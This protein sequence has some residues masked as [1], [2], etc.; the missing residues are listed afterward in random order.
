MNNKEKIQDYCEDQAMILHGLKLLKEKYQRCKNM[1][2]DET[3]KKYY[4]DSVPRIDALIKE[5]QLNLTH[6]KPNRSGDAPA[7]P[8]LQ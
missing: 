6:G 2:N 8:S 1:T 7:R 5:T 4:A 3:L